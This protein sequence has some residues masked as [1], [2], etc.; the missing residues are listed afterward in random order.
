MV[1]KIVYL[2]DVGYQSDELKELRR[3]GENKYMLTD[4]PLVIR[5]P[6]EFHGD[7]GREYCYLCGEEKEEDVDIDIDFSQKQLVH[8]LKANSDGTYS[9]LEYSAT[10]DNR[11]TKIYQKK[12]KSL[13]YRLFQQHLK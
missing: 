5:G 12:P 2:E 7:I 3:I 13:L 6:V 4:G 10:M 11:P 9:K 8:Y 1:L